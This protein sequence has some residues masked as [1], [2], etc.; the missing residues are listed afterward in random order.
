MPDFRPCAKA[1]EIGQT[2]SPPTKGGGTSDQSSPTSRQRRPFFP[3]LRPADPTRLQGLGLDDQD[4]EALDGHVQATWPGEGDFD[5]E[6]ERF[7][8]EALDSQG[9]QPSE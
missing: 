9:P 5:A 4:R 7:P 2:L 3:N 1:G 8:N 6:M